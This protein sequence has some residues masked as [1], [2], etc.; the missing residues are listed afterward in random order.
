M[1][2]KSQRIEPKKQLWS[3]P[4]SDYNKANFAPR[5]IFTCPRCFQKFTPKKLYQMFCSPECE[6]DC[7]EQIHKIREHKLNAKCQVCGA[8]FRRAHESLSTYLCVGC[9][10][11]RQKLLAKTDKPAEWKDKPKPKSLSYTELNRRAEYKRVFDEK[12]WS[13]YCKGRKWD[14]I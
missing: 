1:V 9:K 5:S 7:H 6:E 12:G 13:H 14:R 10:Q 8:Q 3:V 4:E 2:K 11:Q